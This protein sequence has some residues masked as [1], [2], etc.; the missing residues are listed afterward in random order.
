MFII[1]N[2]ETITGC[3]SVKRIVPTYKFIYAMT[4]KIDLSFVY[5]FDQTIIS[6]KGYFL[7]CYYYGSLIYWQTFQ[8]KGYGIL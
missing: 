6:W 3:S 8:I 5:N 2:F 7:Y 4:I 1:S